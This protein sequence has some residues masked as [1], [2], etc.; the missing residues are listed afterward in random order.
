VIWKWEKEI[1]RPK[2]ISFVCHPLIK[3]QHESDL[4]QAVVRIHGQEVLYLSILTD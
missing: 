4:M 3:G 1:K 2:L